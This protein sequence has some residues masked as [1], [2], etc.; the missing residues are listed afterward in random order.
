MQWYLLL[1]DIVEADRAMGDPWGWVDWSNVPVSAEIGAA[2]HA[3][4]AFDPDLKGQ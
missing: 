3:F 2:T 1:K 4:A